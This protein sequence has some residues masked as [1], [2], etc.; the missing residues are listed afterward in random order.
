MKNTDV[1]NSFDL[2]VPITQKTIN[3]QLTH[4]VRL[5]VINPE[6]IITQVWDD[7][8]KQDVYTILKSSADLPK[9]S[10]GSIDSSKLDG[11]LDGILL[12]Q[13]S[14]H[15]SGT[16]VLLLLNFLS[17]TFG[18]WGGSPH[19]PTWMTVDMSNWKFGI[20][21]NMDLA[22]LAK[23]DLDQKIKVP[24]NVQ[25]QLSGFI[26]N[27]FTV[28]HLFMD[29]ESTDLI[30]FDPTVTSVGNA[31][32]DVKKQFV[33]FM[34]E[35]LK[36]Q[37]DAGNPYVLGYTMSA[38]DQS[39]YASYG[40]VPDSLRPVGTTYNFYNDPTNPDIS[41][42]NFALVT[43]GGHQSI[44]T[45][46]GNFDSNWISPNE[47]CD[48]KMIYSHQVLLE[49]YFLKPIFQQLH[50][51]IYAQIKDHL[52]VDSGA[53]YDQAKSAT[54]NGFSYSIINDKDGDDQYVNNYSVQ[55]VNQAQSAQVDLNFSG[56][57]YFYK[58]QS[59][60]MF[61]CTAKGWAWTG[62][63]WSGTVSLITTKDTNGRPN[64]SITKQFSISNVDKG[65]DKNSCA[66]AWTIIGDILGSI[67]DAFSFG[68]DGNFFA[69]LFANA[70][71]I[72]IDS[73]GNIGVVLGDIGTT[74]N[75]ALILPAGNVFFISNPTADPLANF[76]LELHYK[77]EH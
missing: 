77:S 74:I 34:Q 61:F 73:I 51:G 16:V 18:Y 37:K 4:L 21:V 7:P 40:D 24:D 72:H 42:L 19:N 22:T 50:D 39:N 11:Y 70:F 36:S 30:N 46:P 57:L 68:L 48:A 56:H 55:I 47:Q 17:G 35:Y 25:Q 53:N 45:T 66:E 58:E 2:I 12:P 60:D 23:N 6:L 71:G 33:F 75:T 43:K 20:S 32:D 27:M 26:D 8:N 10:D 49:E 65:Q 41:T 76:Y 44:S 15:E 31:G 62:L 13:I 9:N 3:D 64:L 52:S 69:N 29:F 5:G 59:K 14:I 67:L 28:N 54:A 63:D 1:F 38:T